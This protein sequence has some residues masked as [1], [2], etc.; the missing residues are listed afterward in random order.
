MKIT[1]VQAIHLR[2]PEIQQRT[3]VGQALL[4]RGGLPPCPSWGVKSDA[5]KACEGL[6][7]DQQALAI[8]EAP[9]EQAVSRHIDTMRCIW[10][11]VDDEP[12]PNSVRGVIEGQSIALLSNYDRELLDPPSSG[13]LGRFSNRSFVSA[14]GLWNQRRVTE[15]HDSKFLD[16]LKTAIAEGAKL[17]K[18]RAISNTVKPPP[19]APT[20]WWWTQSHET[21]LSW[22]E[23]VG[24]KLRIGNNPPL[25][26]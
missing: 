6:G 1:D 23:N 7:I 11:E 16:A 22:L 8:D 20:S 3:D 5:A 13:W 24:A 12:G 25:I 14:S 15:T 18:S 10:V 9:V 2:L 21:G 4:A 19:L 17:R 26:N